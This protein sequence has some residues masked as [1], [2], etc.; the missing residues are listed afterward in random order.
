MES[1]GVLG[2]LHPQPEGFRNGT[3]LGEGSRGHGVGGGRSTEQRRGI[4]GD[5]KGVGEGLGA[6]GEPAPAREPS[7]V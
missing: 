3:G 7:G 6:H 1:N 4:L 2:S 5:L